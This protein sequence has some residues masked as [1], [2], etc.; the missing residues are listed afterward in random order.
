MLVFLLGVM[1]LDRDLINYLPQVLKEVRELKAIVTAEQPEIIDLWDALEEALN[2]QFINDATEKGV[3]R[4]E[5]ILKV[6]PKATDSLDVRKYRIFARFNEQLPYT[7]KKLQNQLV[8]LCGENGF[9][10]ELDHELYKLIVKV[11]LTAKGKFDEVDSLLKRTAP[12]NM[13][14]DLSLLYNQ[15]QLLA[16]FTHSQLANYTHYELRNEVI[17]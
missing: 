3:K 17:S 11:E 16:S 13:I 12:A 1:S 6:V 5:S 4:L 9:R 8:R 2:D 14:I 10:V 7:F 15:H